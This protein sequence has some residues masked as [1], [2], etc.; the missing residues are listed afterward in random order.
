M[1]VVKILRKAAGRRLSAVKEA[2]FYSRA[3][4]P[5]PDCPAVDGGSMVMPRQSVQIAHNEC[6]QDKGQMDDDIPH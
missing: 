2:L 3:Q 4:R 5:L 1:D 6:R